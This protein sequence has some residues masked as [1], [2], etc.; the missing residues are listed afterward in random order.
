VSR[1][2]FLK[3]QDK[4]KGHPSSYRPICLINTVDK[5]LE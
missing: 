2:M 1:F 3:K 5:F 4:P